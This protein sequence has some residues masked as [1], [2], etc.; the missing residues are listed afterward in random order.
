MSRVVRGALYGAA[1]VL[2]LDTIGS[3]ASRAL[4]FDYAF[5]APMTLLIAIAI[6]AYVGATERVSRAALAG[7]VVGVSDATVGWAIAWAIGP[8]RPQI[9][10]RITLLGFFNTVVF[11][12][13]LGAAGAAVGAWLVRRVRHRPRA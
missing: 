4:G 1:A 10:E 8:G 3:F 5:L 7:A 9:G 11:V 12:A 6:G 2:A 13:V